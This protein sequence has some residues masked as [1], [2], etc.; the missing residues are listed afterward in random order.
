M[1]VLVVLYYYYHY[2][3]LT[4]NKHKTDEIMFFEMSIFVYSL[5]T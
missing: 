1:N 4:N 3:L 2:Y 5:K